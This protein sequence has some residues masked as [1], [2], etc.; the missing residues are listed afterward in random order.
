MLDE[1][2][3]LGPAGDVASE[4]ATHLPLPGQ[5]PSEDSGQALRV[6]QDDKVETPARYLRVA[7]SLP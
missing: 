5:V 6:A 1:V 3:H 2:E 4:V 7:Q